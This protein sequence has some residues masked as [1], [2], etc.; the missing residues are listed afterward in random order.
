MDQKDERKEE[1]REGEKEA[2]EDDT[3]ME[4]VER[5]EEAIGRHKP[6]RRRKS[7]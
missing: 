2:E 6:A 4:H 7:L 3:I 1:K 5:E